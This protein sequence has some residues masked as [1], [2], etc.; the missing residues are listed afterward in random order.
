MAEFNG[1]EITPELIKKAEGCKSAEE[2][3]ALAKENGIDIT[4]DEAQVYLEELSRLELNL[5]DLDDAAG[6]VR[7]CLGA[8]ISE[9]DCPGICRGLFWNDS[10]R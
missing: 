5:D 10:D 1:K 6:G 7:L 4:V 3:V 2:L 9:P 8:I